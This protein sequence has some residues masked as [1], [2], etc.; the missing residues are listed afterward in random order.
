MSCTELL[1][2]NGDFTRFTAMCTS[3]RQPALCRISPAVS[4][5]LQGNWAPA[6]YAVLALVLIL[7]H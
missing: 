7:G 4:H 1:C 3:H 6:V 2:L 5:G